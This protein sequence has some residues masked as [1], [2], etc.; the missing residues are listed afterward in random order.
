MSWERND[1]NA[2][3]PHPADC[4]C[5]KCVSPQRLATVEEL[6]G[7]LREE[8]DPQR[9]ATAWA[10][11]TLTRILAPEWTHVILIKDG[12][13][14]RHETVS[15]PAGQTFGEREGLEQRLANLCWELR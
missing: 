12:K 7:I 1:P 2:P 6:D 14:A 15:K 5:R 9:R 13:S 8:A 3:W 11:L 10:A 4:M